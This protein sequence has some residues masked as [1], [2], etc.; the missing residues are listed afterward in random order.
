MRLII[1]EH[2]F[3]QVEYDAPGRFWACACGEP[4][5]EVPEELPS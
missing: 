3:E 4:G 2:E 1:H 5:Y